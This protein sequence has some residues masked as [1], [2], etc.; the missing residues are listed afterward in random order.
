MKERLDD[1]KKIVHQS[2][3]R[4]V[5]TDSFM[6][7][8]K[9]QK[10][11]NGDIIVINNS[12]IFRE[13]KLVKTAKSNLYLCMKCID[14]TG[15]LDGPYV[16]E[17]GDQNS[18]FKLYSTKAKNMP[19]L[20]TLDDALEIQI[21]QL[22]WLVFVLIGKLEEVPVIVP[23]DNKYVKQLKF[24]PKSKA[25]GV[26]L[27]EGGQKIIATN[28]I[29]DP[30]STW[31]A[32]EKDLQSTIEDPSA[33]NSLKN[34]YAVAFENL[35]KEAYLRMELPKPGELNGDS[36]NSFIAKLRKSV[37]EQY[38]Q[39]VSAIRKAKSDDTYIREV[40]RI[41]YN[42]ADD[43]IKVLLLLVSVADLKP[44]LLWCT[45][46]EHY[47]VAEAFRKLPWT[48][49]HKKPKLTTYKEIIHGARNRAFHSL[50]AFDRTVQVELGGVDVKVRRLTLL[51]PYK[52]RRDTIPLDYEDR[53]MVELLTEL[54]RAPEV[55][56]PFDF[57]EK[58][59][60]IMRT[61]EILL[62]KTEETLWILNSLRNK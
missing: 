29:T 24:D 58:N 14:N 20:L 21:R 7:W 34:A 17:S 59:A 46:Q 27:S 35:R 57:W 43:A 54:T 44:V 6:D 15:Q 53:E 19:T 4:L 28:T 10:L 37:T 5:S 39:Y 32:I 38:Q 25:P 31:E 22:G 48:K 56:V 49:A 2:V 61:F 42:F 3:Q 45:I 50:F 9:S 52:R 51:P 55:V 60:E 11:A 18:D 62:A 40:M 47:N 33:I 1:L 26:V 36:E 12:F 30:G 8:L 41:A 23:I 13:K 16:C